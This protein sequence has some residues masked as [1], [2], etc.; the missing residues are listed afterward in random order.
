MELLKYK[1]GEVD[2]LIFMLEGKGFEL[3]FVDTDS[4]QA[5][6]EGNHGN[7]R[8]S[9]KVYQKFSE[10]AFSSPQV[11]LYHASAKKYTRY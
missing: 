8:K 11:S 10:P 3:S 4:L 6:K 7:Y 9:R 2:E 5:K 1:N